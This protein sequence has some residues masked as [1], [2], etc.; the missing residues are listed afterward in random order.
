MRTKL[1]SSWASLRPAA[2]ICASSSS[3]LRVPIRS[4][5]LDAE[6]ALVD[7]LS[8]MRTKGRVDLRA[9]REPSRERPATADL[10]AIYRE[11]A[12]DVSRW[13]RRLGG[14]QAD[15]EDLLHEVFLVVQR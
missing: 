9:A 14:P 10:D 12:A 1:T 7:A 3:S 2:S 6:A 8:G 15:V 11:H 5:G 4:S 13:A